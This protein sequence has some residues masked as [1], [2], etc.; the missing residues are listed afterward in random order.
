MFS[1]S[2]MWENYD[3]NDISKLKEMYKKLVQSTNFNYEGGGS[4]N[5]LRSEGKEERI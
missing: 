2:K 1:I 4:I 5:N 3:F